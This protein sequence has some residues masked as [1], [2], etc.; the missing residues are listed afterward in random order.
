M[1]TRTIGLAILATLVAAAPAA[2][3]P[4]H[5]F[6]GTEPQE[7]SWAGA[8]GGG[9][10][11]VLAQVGCHEGVNCD[12]TLFEVT[13]PGPLTLRTTGDLDTLVDGDVHLYVSD[14]AG[15]V[16]QEIGAATNFTP[17]E[18]LTVDVDPGYYVMMYAYTGFGT[19]S[20]EASW[21]PR[22]PEEEEPPFEE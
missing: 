15:A 8:P 20:G 18:T 1:S 12:Y 16:G 10:S 5:T 13:D 21:M 17:N 4:D 22:P 19:Y 9:L 7:W 2:A 6:G 3:A 11:D 14:E